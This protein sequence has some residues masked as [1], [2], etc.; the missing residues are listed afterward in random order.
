MD[1]DLRGQLLPDE[2]AREVPAPKSLHLMCK[3]PS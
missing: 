3:R 2:D 1:Q